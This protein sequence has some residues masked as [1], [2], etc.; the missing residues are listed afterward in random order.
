[1]CN[2]YSYLQD[3]I[4]AFHMILVC[5]NGNN[6]EVCV[7]GPWN[8]NCRLQTTSVRNESLRNRYESER[9]SYHVA[10]PSAGYYL[11]AL[12]AVYIDACTLVPRK[13]DGGTENSS[14]TSFTLQQ[15]PSLEKLHHQNIM[16]S[17]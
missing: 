7:K 3:G 5:L 1:M 13:R 8:P 2:E 4:K 14:G 15:I 17:F 16:R 9:S 10:M 11:E 6:S 12:R